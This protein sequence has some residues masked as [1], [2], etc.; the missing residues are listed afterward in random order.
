VDVGI[1]SL[2]HKRLALASYQ[3]LAFRKTHKNSYIRFVLLHDSNE[4]FEGLV[5][6]CVQGGEGS[7]SDKYVGE[8]CNRQNQLI[9]TLPYCI[10]DSW[11]VASIWTGTSPQKWIKQKVLF[12]HS[13]PAN[14]N[15]EEKVSHL[16]INPF[17]KR[18]D[19]IMVFETNFISSIAIIFCE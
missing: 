18:E 1:E 15:F 10:P 12:T 14:H 17:S 13:T 19:K 4:I 5:T 2:F 8:I 6:D 7:S 3:Y 16:V 11:C 9:E